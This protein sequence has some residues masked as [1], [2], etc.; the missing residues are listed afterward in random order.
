MNF[1]IFK[2][3]TKDDFLN[4]EKFIDKSDRSKYTFLRSDEPVLNGNVGC[5]C[6]YNE[7]LG[8][9]EK[10]TADSFVF[11]TYLFNKRITIQVNLKD[12]EVIK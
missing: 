10:L 6:R 3:M 1:Q 8:N 2:V 11:Y 9:V 5:I 4:C 12:L 7:Y